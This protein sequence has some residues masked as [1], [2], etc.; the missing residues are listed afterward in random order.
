MAWVVEGLDGRFATGSTG[1]S[2]S[3]GKTPQTV[4]HSVLISVTM[5]F[6]SA[7]RGK[8]GNVVEVLTDKC[9][10]VWENLRLD[11]SSNEMVLYVLKINVEAW[12]VRG[13][14]VMIKEWGLFCR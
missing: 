11:S 7:W 6:W 13:Y 8:V 9:V 10:E 3:S 5:C 12:W 1:F 2:E 4:T 14:E